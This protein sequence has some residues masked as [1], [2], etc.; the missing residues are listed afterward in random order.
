MQEW[1]KASF[2]VLDSPW[3]YLLTLGLILSISF[4]CPVPFALV[5]LILLQLQ[6]SER[7]TQGPSYLR[8][9]L[10]LEV[11]VTGVMWA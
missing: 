7:D 5:P 2:N 11:A 6:Q 4:K 8:T 10:V 9:V 1:V 3:K